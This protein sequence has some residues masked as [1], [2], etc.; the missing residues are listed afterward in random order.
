ME[1]KMVKLTKSELLR[2]NV[3]KEHELSESYN[4]IGDLVDK[5]GRNASIEARVENGYYGDDPDYPVLYV[6]ET[7]LETDEEYNTR[8]ESLKKYKQSE[9]DQKKAKR[10]QAQIDELALYEK[11]KEKY[12]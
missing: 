11:L 3:Y 6:T 4:N 10:K 7:R 9:I 5:F 1:D 12:G 2:R 8:I